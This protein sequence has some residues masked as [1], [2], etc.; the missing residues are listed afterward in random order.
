MGREN[1]LCGSPYRAL[2]ANGERCDDQG[3]TKEPAAVFISEL[4]DAANETSRMTKMQCAR[5]LQRAAITL[6]RGYRQ[7]IDYSKTPANARFQSGAVYRWPEMPLRID[8]LTD[9][10]I[11]SELRYAAALVKAAAAEPE[12]NARG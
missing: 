10:D 3:M 11:S 7:K 6:R 8:A 4:T 12:G 1:A 9:E 5:L 2:V